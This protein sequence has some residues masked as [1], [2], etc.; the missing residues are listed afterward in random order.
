MRDMFDEFM[1]E[2]RRRQEAA[3]GGSGD[4]DP[5][6]RPPADDAEE[7]SESDAEDTTPVAD[8]DDDVPDGPEPTPIDVH[9]EAPGTRRGPTPGRR[10]PYGR[11]PGRF[12]SG[13]PGGPRRPGGP[14]DGARS[15][16][17]GRR[18]GL[19]VVVGAIVLILILGGSVVNFVTDAIW[20]KSVGYDSVFWT[21]ILTQG[22][23]FI[24]AFIVA[25]V[26]LLG[27]LWLAD[28]AV[29]AV[30]GGPTSGGSFLDRLVEAAQRADGRISQSRGGD[31][32]Q[33]RFGSD[34]S[35]FERPVR[36]GGPA[37]PAGQSIFLG[38]EELPSMT[39][40]VR[41][42]LVVVAVLF[43]LGI[44]GT[45]AGQWETIQLWAH[46][47]PYAPAGSPA[48]T[49]PIFGRDIGF[50]LFQLPFLRLAQSLAT[51]LLI[52]GL[53]LAGAR[54]LVG[55]V[56]AGLT[57]TTRVRVHLGALGGLL[58]ILVAVG[59]QLDKLELV[60]SNRGVATGVSFTDQN[61]QFIAF[62]GLTVIAA[63]A[64]AFLVGAAF[65]RWVW[66]LGLVVVAWLAAS[67]VL[68]TIYP[69][70]I[71][72]FT[73]EP[74][75][76]AQETPY[77]LNNINMTRLAFGLSDWNATPFN[78][79]QPLTADI[80]RSE[81]ATF[82]NARLWDYR[83]L[84]DT[85]D[86][87]QT[88]RQYYDF[89]D[90]D[91]DRYMINGQLR[92][93]MLSGRELAPDKNPQASSWV[94]QKITFTHG[95]GLA[96]V[97]VNQATS[98][99][100]PDLIIKDLPPVS[101][102]GAPPVTQPRIYFGERDADYVVVDAKQAA[103]DYP[104]GT[105]AD[106]SGGADAPAWTG[107]TGIKLDTL[108]SRL[109]FGIRFRDLNLLIS[110][111]VT[112]D[113]QLLFHRTLIDRVS[114][115]APF[116]RF[117]KDPYLVVTDTGRLEYIQ[118]AYT[119]SDKF[120][121]AQSF[122]GSSL[123]AGSGL[124]GDSFNYIRNSVKI[125]MDAYDGTMTFYV[126]DPTDPIIRAYE[127]VFPNLF[128]SLDK[129]PAD[130]QAHLRTPEEM[131]NVQIDQFARY[132]VTTAA[133]FQQNNDLWTVPTAPA[134]DQSLPSEA[135]YVVMR[136]PDSPKPEFLLLQPMV[137]RSR[138]NMIAWVAAQN[139]GADRGKV[140]VYQFP[141]DTSVLGPVQ[142]EAKI[143]IEP[144]ISSQITLWN[145][146]GS[147]VIKGNLIVMPL[148]DSLIYLQPIYLKST[149]TAFPQLEK[150]VLANSTTVVWGNTLQEA[151]NLL[152][153]GGFSGTPTPTPTPTPGSSPGV[154]PA[155][156][157]SGGPVATPPA[158]VQALVAYANQHFEL[159]QAALKNGDFAT[160]GNEI[161]LVQ[162]AL[163]RLDALVGPTLAPS[164]PS[165][166]PSAGA[167]PSP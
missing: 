67:F 122:D 167:S 163:Q 145:Q 4:P 154:T 112:A 78:G 46:Q 165:P 93:V 149:S 25:L 44:A 17:R 138:P 38:G 152:L 8:G 135:Y 49:D 13:G 32:Y 90:V 47:V 64:G 144:T 124:A 77:I 96:M 18:I 16:G 156:T 166:A 100:Q 3:T 37:G 45:V 117:D 119:I 101:T 84:G 106:S 114:L 59:Y 86:Q 61:A 151:L 11:G 146:S 63:L 108:L 155:P 27:G 82:Q 99:G 12:G 9:R 1:N 79:D 160:Y 10:S 158:D 148:Q 76:L 147:S 136:L 162:Q 69:T 65:T 31:Q 75:Q 40:I 54:F 2:L 71:Q 128:T 52:G 126:S 137:P 66:P 130:L 115:I 116:L 87:L 127:G 15:G 43:A 26:F 58:L 141:Q 70:I 140:R 21:R 20:Y 53:F 7:P 6:T 110:D 159:A 131:F 103:F 50:F 56:E 89:T 30:T 153:A 55:I 91:T 85:L 95:I 51:S 111:Q 29:P 113:S 102:A 157:P 134:N 48:V 24:G 74:N 60:Y 109:L 121:N 150:V 97:P 36:P 19:T 81:D 88:I 94:N 39:P 133:S 143:D 23:L 28:K 161:A 139:D 41:I 42:G 92:Q 34:E 57:G 22:G 5:T 125:V 164:T 73:V 142:I 104:V 107:T 14:D 62:D 33:G 83:P 123:D 35:R 129:M 98:N 80:V 118:D 120:P 105:A 132:H 72:K 68:G